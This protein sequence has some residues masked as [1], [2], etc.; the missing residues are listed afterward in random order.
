MF[1]PADLAEARER[2]RQRARPEGSAERI[3][4]VLRRVDRKLEARDVI[5]R[6]LSNGSTL[7]QQS[8]FQPPN[9]SWHVEPRD[10][11]FAHVPVRVEARHGSDAEF[12]RSSDADG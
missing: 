2:S 7:V 9:R 8:H 5:A 10:R 6:Y 1:E 11:C 4:V 12:S 3:D